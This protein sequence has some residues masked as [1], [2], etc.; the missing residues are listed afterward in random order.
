MD[1]LV[2][3]KGGTKRLYK[4]VILGVSSLVIFLITFLTISNVSL[5]TQVNN[6]A[7]QNT[8]LYKMRDS[9]I[10]IN[11]DCYLIVDSLKT[12]VYKVDKYYRMFYDS[13]DTLLP[14]YVRIF[15]ISRIP[16]GWPTTGIVSSPFGPRKRDFHKGID[17]AN[18]TGTNVWATSGGYVDYE[19]TMRGYGNIVIINH[20]NGYKTW[21][22]HLSAI[23]VRAGQR[24]EEG[25]T[26]AR[27]GSSGEATGPHLHY[28]VRYLGHPLNPNR[29]L[30][31]VW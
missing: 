15:K 6:L 5:V 10:T 18:N 13:N 11:R 14:I 17:I 30:K 16:Y 24:V 26:I 21:Y 20:G 3:H 23:Y 7:K 2:V 29:F 27:M 12:L 25:Q 28:E 4:R 22:A 19:G 9:L 31:V 1:L 8:K